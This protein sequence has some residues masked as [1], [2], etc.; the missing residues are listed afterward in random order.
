MNDVI[1]VIGG[2]ISVTAASTAL[3]ALWSLAP[4]LH[5]ILGRTR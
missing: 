1:N 3:L 5:R 4:R 2:F